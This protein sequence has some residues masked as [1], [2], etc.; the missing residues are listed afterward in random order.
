MRADSCHA[1]LPRRIRLSALA[2][3]AAAALAI[4]VAS[5]G[6][7]SQPGASPTGS[8]P[9][10]VVL[11]PS[12]EPGRPTVADA[13][14]RAS[15]LRAIGAFESANGG[16]AQVSLVTVESL[17]KVNETWIER[18]TVESK[19][20]RVP[21]SVKLRPGAA[22]GIDFDVQRLASERIR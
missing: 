1:D 15:V 8:S 14:T 10:S 7:A 18:W 21:Y 2:A 12:T 19:G 4:A 11:T 22:G 5:G 9:P 13:P 17:G 6:C 3:T 20:R 16:S